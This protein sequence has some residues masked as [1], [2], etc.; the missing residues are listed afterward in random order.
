MTLNTIIIATLLMSPFVSATTTQQKLVVG[1]GEKLPPFVF[2]QSNSGLTVDIITAALTPLGYK[3]EALYYPYTRRAKDYKKD[4]I[5][6]V[7]DI[8]LNTANGNLL[9][10]YL[11]SESYVYEN[12]AVALSKNNFN[13]SK[14]ADLKNYSLLS[15][16]SAAIHLGDEYANMVK[17]NPRYNEI[18]DQ[19]LQVKFL[20]LNKVDVIQMDKQSFNYFRANI[21]DIDTTQKIDRFALFGKS[22]NGYL[23][24]SKKVRDDFNLQLQKLKET[25][26]YKQI[27][28]SYLK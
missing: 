23:F 10:G 2:P 6:V 4:K 21:K 5:D 17:A 20:Y 19:S 7:A 28:D 27:F 18:H 22:P 1:F 14:I 24:K 13:L 3:I 26:K 25:G 11:S 16:P 15:W 12:V 8:N 9:K